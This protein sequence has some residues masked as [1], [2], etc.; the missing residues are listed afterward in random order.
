[1]ALPEGMAPSSAETIASLNEHLIQVL[2]EVSL[3]EEM[4]KKMDNALE[5]YRRKFALVRHQQGLLYSEQA[6]NQRQW[7]EERE[8]MEAKIKELEGAKSEDNVRLDEFDRLVDTL[9]RDESEV[10]RRVAETTRKITVLQVNE[11][12]LVRRFQALEDVEQFLRRENNRLKN[13]IIQ[14]EAVVQE[15][16]GYYRRYKDMAAFKVSCNLWRL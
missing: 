15:R 6:E 14:M 2:Q 8:K 10:R 4:I 5:S 9:S 16:L 13:D 1:M 11:K 3:K 12:A 7:E